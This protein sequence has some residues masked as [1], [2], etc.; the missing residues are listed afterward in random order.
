MA[1]GWWGDG[2]GGWGDGWGGSINMTKKEEA[3]YLTTFAF[4]LCSAFP[5]SVCVEH[6]YAH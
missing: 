6:L 2:G 4:L 3:I 1:G 5:S